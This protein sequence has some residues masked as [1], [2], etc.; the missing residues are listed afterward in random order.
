LIR[1]SILI[2]SL[3]FGTL[4]SQ[5]Q[6][7]ASSIKKNPNFTYELNNPNMF[8]NLAIT[9]VISYYNGFSN[10]VLPLDLGSPTLL[11]E[12]VNNDT[13]DFKQTLSKSSLSQGRLS[14][15]N[16][17]LGDTPQEVRYVLGKPLNIENDKKAQS[18]SYE[19]DSYSV[20]FD[21]Q[22]KKVDYILVYKDINLTESDVVNLLGEPNHTDLFTDEQFYYYEYGKFIFSISINGSSHKVESIDLSVITD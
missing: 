9:H 10:A 11:K 17:S 19:Y 13:L 22:T 16:I 6:V 18:L 12:N 20:F 8:T 7:Q 15:I 1:L 3:I 5:Q 2:P 21:Y 14:T 4:L